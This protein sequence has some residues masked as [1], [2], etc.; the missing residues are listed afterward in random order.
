[1]E[2]MAAVVRE[3]G[4]P[5]LIEQMELDAPRPTEVLVRI[6]A[7]GMCHTDIVARDQLVPTPL[8]QVLGHEGAGVVEAVGSE[9]HTVQPGDHVVLSF[10]FCGHCPS[11]TQGKPSYCYNFGAHNFR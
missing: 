2:I 8:P 10:G 7:T 5:F 1:M 3:A 4:G 9:V 11:C 6:I